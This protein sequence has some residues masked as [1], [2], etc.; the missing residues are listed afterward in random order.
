MFTDERREALIGLIVEEATRD[1]EP[2]HRR[3]SAYSSSE[4]M[5][6]WQCMTRLALA[7]RAELYPT[8]N[9]IRL[10][11]GSTVK[12]EHVEIV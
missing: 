8:R 5:H 7:H 3:V 4:V 11:N 1:A 12:V 10:P 6:Y 9:E 2:C